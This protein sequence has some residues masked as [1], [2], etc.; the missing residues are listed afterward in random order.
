MDNVKFWRAWK[1]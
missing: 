1:A